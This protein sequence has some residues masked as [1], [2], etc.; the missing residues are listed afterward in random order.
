MVSRGANYFPCP[1]VV[2]LIDI[3]AN[4]FVGRRFRSASLIVRQRKGPV[5]S[6]AMIRSTGYNL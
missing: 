1:V 3:S 4:L 5:N 6:V 2:V